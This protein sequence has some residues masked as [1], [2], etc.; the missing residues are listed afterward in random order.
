MEPVDLWERYI[1][2]EFAARALRRLNERRWDE[3][4]LGQMMSLKV[5]LPAT[6]LRGN[7]EPRFS[8]ALAR[9]AT[10]TEHPSRCQTA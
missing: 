4:A 5:H 8:L 6:Y 10:G 3:A 7:S 9:K 2:P 1:D